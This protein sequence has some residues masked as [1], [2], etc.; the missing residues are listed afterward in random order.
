M[1]TNKVNLGTNFLHHD[2]L[3]CFRSFYSD[4]DRKTYALAH[5]LK[6]ILISQ[7]LRVAPEELSFSKTIHGKPYIDGLSFNISHSQDWVAIYLSHSVDVGV[8]IEASDRPE[9]H[10]LMDVFLL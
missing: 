2:E 10:S 8:D 1:N 9:L 7:K 4:R 5:Q 6:R 3:R